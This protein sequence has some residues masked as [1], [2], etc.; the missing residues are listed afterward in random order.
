MTL[1]ELEAGAGGDGQLLARFGRGAQGDVL[2]DLVD[3]GPHAIV[4]GMTGTGKSELLTSWV[5]GI[6]TI[7]TSLV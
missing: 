3:D 5:E 1:G 2:V 7:R 4:T 6:G